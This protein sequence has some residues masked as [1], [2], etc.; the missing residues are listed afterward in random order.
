M[1]RLF[2]YKLLARVLPADVRLP[3]GLPEQIDYPELTDVVAMY[4][5]RLRISPDEAAARLPDPGKLESALQRPYTHAL[6]EEADFPRQASVLAHAIS[7]GHCFDD[8]NKRL[9]YV[10]TVAFLLGHGYRLAVSRAR[11]TAWMVML[12]EPGETEN[13]ERWTIDNL[14]V[15]LR[16]ALTLS[17]HDLAR[18]LFQ[19]R[20]RRSLPR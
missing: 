3:R 17:V 20:A 9:A 19:L 7:E 12:S 8:G 2:V 11:F 15:Q 14:E 4:G 16:R 6:Y 13:R 10:V 5:V 1:P 18:H